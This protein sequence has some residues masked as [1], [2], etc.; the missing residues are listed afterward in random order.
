MITT[1]K[2]IATNIIQR[3]DPAYLAKLDAE[4]APYR[5]EVVSGANAMLEFTNIGDRGHRFFQDHFVTA[6]FS[7]DSHGVL[8]PNLSY[9]VVG[10]NNGVVELID[11]YMLSS[12]D[13][14]FDLV[15][16][17]VVQLTPGNTTAGIEPDYKAL[18]VK[19]L[20]CGGKEKSNALLHVIWQA[21]QRKGIMDSPKETERVKR[22][23][24]MLE[25]PEYCGIVID[26]ILE[27]KAV[28]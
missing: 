20:T 17:G 7:T 8:I 5:K 15:S 26:T 1:R 23:R 21:E 24:V 22:L 19:L 25:S 9:R 14:F 3:V 10:T 13:V 12:A 11:E 4:D 6:Q 27:G 18:L 16:P 28:A 2:R